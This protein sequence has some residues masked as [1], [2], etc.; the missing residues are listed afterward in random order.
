MLTA[1]RLTKLEQYRFGFCYSILAVLA[2]FVSIVMVGGCSAPE[3][4]VLVAPS[5]GFSTKSEI[6]NLNIKC[7]KKIIESIVP[8]IPEG[9]RI[10]LVKSGVNDYYDDI[11]WGE[12]RN[13]GISVK[14]GYFDDLQDD[15]LDYYLLAHPRAKGTVGEGFPSKSTYV[16]MKYLITLVDAKSMIIVWSE[17]MVMQEVKAFDLDKV[18]GVFGL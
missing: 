1:G 11:L 17:E 2:A 10:G 4:V 16:S 12:L 3:K 14:K 7:F 18:G 15:R 13:N 6:Q 9:K 8:K 5:C